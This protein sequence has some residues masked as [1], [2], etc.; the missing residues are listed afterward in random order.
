MSKRN[1]LIFSHILC[2]YV[3]VRARVCVC[4]IILGTVYSFRPQ[5][6]SVVPRSF[7]RHSY[8]FGHIQLD[9]YN[10]AAAVE[11]NWLWLWSVWHANGI[12]WGYWGK[13]FPITTEKKAQLLKC[14][15]DMSY[16]NLIGG[17]AIVSVFRH[18]KH[19][20][21]NEFGKTHCCRG[22]SNFTTCRRAG[23]SPGH[24]RHV[25]AERVCIFTDTLHS[26]GALKY[27]TIKY[28][29]VWTIMRHCR[30]T[31][32][33]CHSLDA[34]MLGYVLGFR[35]GIIPLCGG[36]FF[37]VVASSAANAWTQRWLLGHKTQRRFMSE[38][39]AIDTHTHTRSTIKWLAITSEQREFA[40]AWNECRDFHPKRYALHFGM[41]PRS[42]VNLIK[43]KREAERWSDAIALIVRA[44]TARLSNLIEFFFGQMQFKQWN[45]SPCR[46]ALPTTIMV[47]K[48]L[49]W[50]T[51]MSYQRTNC[52]FDMEPA[53]MGRNQ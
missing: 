37:A 46:R 6:C 8:Q 16:Q 11:S 43:S 22:F 32:L 2:V 42:V 10:C 12:M 15:C 31:R 21:S 36:H 27:L 19:Q 26:D 4:R 50:Y 47:L 25:R 5:L 1:S 14:I 33:D 34:S 23:I 3:C 39:I 51:R 45:L 41:R 35:S 44:A 20:I 29:I 53:R 30:C 49:L 13:P 17:I 18:S 28:F 52:A 38:K 9:P 48:T 7:A 24:S 40:L